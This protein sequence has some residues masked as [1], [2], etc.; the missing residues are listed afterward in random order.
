MSILNDILK[1]GVDAVSGKL[2]IDPAQAESL[3]DKVM[4]S[5][6]PAAEETA[7]AEATDEQP[8]EAQA[9]DQVAGETAEAEGE[10]TGLL[11]QA[12]AM[13]GGSAGLMDKAKQMLGQ[14]GDGNPLN[15]IAGMASKLFSRT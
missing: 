11:G 5:D 13:V 7:V 15:D 6:A 10:P 3:L 8:S 12:S 2:G 14:D 9:T 1:T 4:P